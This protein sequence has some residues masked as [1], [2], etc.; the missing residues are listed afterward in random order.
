M[1]K[2]PLFIAGFFYTT[3]VLAQ[4]AQCSYVAVPVYATMYEGFA[5]PFRAE[6]GVNM[7]PEGPCTNALTNPESPENGETVQTQY[8]PMCKL[9]N[10]KTLPCYP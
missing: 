2:I 9:N 1:K 10:G 3:W 8:G 5:V 6:V 7:V 4:A